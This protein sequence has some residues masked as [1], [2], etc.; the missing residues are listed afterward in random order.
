MDIA[1]LQ[2]EA[3]AIRDEN[4]EEFNSANRVGSF[5]LNFI[6]YVEEDGDWAQQNW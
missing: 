1:T 5:L 6:E 2:Q 4:R 3:S